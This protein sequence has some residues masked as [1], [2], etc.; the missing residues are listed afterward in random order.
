LSIAAIGGLVS[1]AAFPLLNVWLIDAFGWR[2]SWLV[3]GAIIIG[4]FTPLA[5]FLIRNS[6]ED[7]GLLP[8]NGDAGEKDRQKKRNEE[9]SWSVSEASKTHAF[10]LLIVC[11]AIPGIVN[12][13]LIFHHVSIFKENSLSLEAAAGILSLTA[14]I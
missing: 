9:A 3:L 6:P 4:M 12:T 8:D 5:L 10:W 13:G 1:S 11:D 2:M 14:L 7:V